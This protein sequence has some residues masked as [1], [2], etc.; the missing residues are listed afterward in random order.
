LLPGLT[1]I[2]EHTLGLLGEQSFET[3]GDYP[4]LLFEG[5]WH[6]SRE[7]FERSCRL[8]AG[9]TALGVTAGERVVVTMAN[10]PEVGV[11]YQAVWRA[12]AAVTPA[13]FLLSTEELRHVIA[14]SQ[15]CAVITTAEFAPKVRDAARALDHVRFLISSGPDDEGFLELS[16]VEA[17]E[18]GPIVP[19]S[20]DDL[21]A[22]LYTGGTT[23]RSKGVMLS[24]SNLCFAGRSAYQSGHVAGLNRMLT[25]LPLSH[26]FGLL[27]TIT[28]MHSDEQGVTVLLRWFQPTTFLE[29]IHEH[30]LQMTAV[31]PSMLQLLLGEPLEDYDISSLRYVNSG[32]APL[33]PE[34]EQEFSRRV[35]S[36]TV[37]QGYG[38]TETAAVVSST[39]VGRERPG[40]V[41]LPVPDSEVRIVDDDGGTLPSGRPGEV[42][43]RSPGVMRGYWRAPEATATALRDGWLHT[44]DIGYL[45]EDGYLYI[46]D[47]KKD[48]II[49]GG[50]N[51]YPR[52]VEDALVE[53]PSVQMAAVVGKADVVHGEEIVAFVAIAPGSGT[54]P[55]ELVDW[56]RAHIGAYKYPREVHLVPSIPLTTVGKIDRKVLRAQLESR[57]TGEQ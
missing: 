45:D 46:V 29:M 26:A 13:T 2:G 34:V 4:A 43:C 1:A 49:R 31:V 10:G 5:R 54:T 9:L 21:A 17:S 35:P 3:R 14:H 38:L 32:G 44:G 20:N 6:S 51:V 50:F 39:P 47:R 22:L 40:S 53:H 11:V 18:P 7:L 28:A 56:S 48:L 41:G 37:R 25:T 36:V 16:S 15:A 30:R 8:A 33:P 55:E 27:V 23:G 19:R 42:C 52:D 57:A 12:G 24:H